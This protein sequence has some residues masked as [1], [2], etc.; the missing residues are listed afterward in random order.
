VSKYLSQFGFEKVE[1][2]CRETNLFSINV[3]QKVAEEISV[4]I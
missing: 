3:T 2:L 4:L 1:W